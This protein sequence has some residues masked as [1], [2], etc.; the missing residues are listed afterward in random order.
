DRGGQLLGQLVVVLAVGEQDGVLLRQRRDGVEQFAGEGQPGAHGG[1]TLGGELAERL[2]RGGP[3]GGVHLHHPGT[4]PDRRVG[5]IVLVV[6]GDHGEP[7][8]VEDLVDRRGG[9]HLGRLHVG[10]A[11]RTGGVDDD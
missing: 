10:P 9:G 8:A 11:H 1:A 7:G 2:V 5:Q 6:P 3:G 4:G